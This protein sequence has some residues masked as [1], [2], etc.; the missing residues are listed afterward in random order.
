MDTR[1]SIEIMYTRRHFEDVAEIFRIESAKLDKAEEDKDP[2]ALGRKHQI[3][4]LIRK[5]KDTFKQRNPNFNPETF[6]KWIDK[7]H[8]S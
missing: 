6:Q 7:R 1:R 8:N 2:F 5:F 4:V 3:E